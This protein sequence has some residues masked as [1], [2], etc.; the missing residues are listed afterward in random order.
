MVVA[1]VGAPGDEDAP[2]ED[3][4]AVFE[5]PS[6]HAPAIVTTRPTT[7]SRRIF[8][9]PSRSSAIHST[10]RALCRVHVPVK[11][12]ERILEGTENVDC[13]GLAQLGGR[14]VATRYPSR[15]GP[16]RLG[17]GDVPPA[18]SQGNFLAESDARAYRRFTM[19]DQ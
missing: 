4:G 17:G 11:A 5:L 16:G 10:L 19:L 8:W 7:T 1:A 3:V 6:V 13:S 12:R 15:D 2:T 9:L 14:V 18:Y